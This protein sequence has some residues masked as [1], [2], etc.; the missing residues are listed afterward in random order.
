MGEIVAEP[1]EPFRPGTLIRYLDAPAGNVMRYLGWDPQQDMTAFL[2]IETVTPP[3]SRL[4]K[5]I[6]RGALFPNKDA[7][8]VVSE[9]VRPR[10]MEEWDDAKHDNSED[11]AR[12][13]EKFGQIG[14]MLVHGG[15]SML[16]NGEFRN[17][18]IKRAAAEAQVSEQWIRRLLAQYWF[19]GANKNSLL[20]RREDQ[21]GP[22]VPRVDVNTKKP[23]PPLATVKRNP[24][25][26]F[27]GAHMTREL[28]DK[29]AAFLIR[30]AK[31]IHAQK[32]QV[33][34]TGQFRLTELWDEF[35]DTEL[36][37]EKKEGG[38]PIK[39]PIPLHRLPR[40]RRFIEFGKEI[41]RKNILTEY[42]VNEADWLAKRARLG[43]STDHTRTRVTIYELD[44]LLFNAE[45]LWGKNS[46]N[47]EGVGKAVVMLG[48]CVQST[49]IVGVHVTIQNESANAYR[50]CLFNAFS[51]KAELLE[52]MGLGHLAGG[53]VYGAS[54]E[55]RFDRGPGKSR[56]LVNPLIDDMKIG[57]R[58]A[59]A[60]RGRD[61][62]IVEAANKF[63]QEK[64]KR[65][66]GS[67]VRSVA[68]HDKDA[69]AKSEWWARIQFEKFVELV[70]T[71]VHDWNTT[72]D[73]FDRLPE[74]MVK[75]GKWKGDIATP[76]GFFDHLR[77]I[78]LADAAVEWSPEETY[79]K[80]IESVPAQVSEGTVSVD[81][82]RYTSDALKALW[83]M[84]VSTPSGKRGEL[85]IN[86]KRHPDTNHF[87]VWV[88]E[89]G[90]IE[91]LT[92]M[93]DSR[94]RF[95]RN[96]WLIHQLRQTAKADS[97]YRR[98]LAARK[99]QLPALMRQSIAEAL[100]L[101]KR[102]RRA[103]VAKSANRSAKAEAE[104]LAAERRAFDTFN[105]DLPESW[106]VVPLEQATGRYNPDEDERFAG[107]I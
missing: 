63:I 59:R 96:V 95:G 102:P 22:D 2:E 21:G 17:Q 15:N 40:K 70:L 51:Q 85:W 4:P 88:K 68:G 105:V 82:A 23:G 47:P 52:T 60:R 77:G 62:S 44:G 35:R 49:A 39:V 84:H 26:R 89:D 54:D 100:A 55:V 31:E 93:S 37:E 65:M 5:L 57:V 71:F 64:L 97:A 90:K 27:R 3:A 72:R 45:L 80:L 53:F 8:E 43:H 13:D 6:P 33:G 24:R 94:R 106:S 73:V 20:P 9:C 86:V 42:F 91:Q 78:R 104:R 74:W 12:R 25:T 46:L 87:I 16:F 79:S 76:K 30:R 75:D 66:P 1:I 101:P 83:N 29:W 34:L 19:Y 61:K 67:Y 69:K 32:G 28:L 7:W 107:D 11:I 10:W 92:I 41:W 18:L 98:E 56:G 99:A 36:I 58:F 48:V 81:S 38:L 103:S 50:N 14:V